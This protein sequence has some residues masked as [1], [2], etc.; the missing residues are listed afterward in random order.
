[1]SHVVSSSFSISSAKFDAEFLK[2]RFPWPVVESSAYPPSG[3]ADFYVTVF[4]LGVG[5]HKRTDK[6]LVAAKAAMLQ[7][8][9]EFAA[10]SDDC[11]YALWV[12]YRFSSKDGA[13]NINPSVSSALGLLN[14]E[15]IFHLQPK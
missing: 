7:Q 5:E 8:E 1:M 3:K 9:S 13:I 10:L 4:D 14:V 2:D 15:L 11:K 12:T 6:H